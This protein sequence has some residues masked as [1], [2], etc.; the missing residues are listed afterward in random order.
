MDNSD[1]NYDTNPNVNIN[2]DPNADSD[3]KT[4]NMLL[5][6]SPIAQEQIK[7]KPH[8]TWHDPQS[9]AIRVKVWRSTVAKYMKFTPEKPTIKYNHAPTQEELDE[10]K[11]YANTQVSVIEED[12]LNA[13]EQLINEGYNP[14]VLNMADWYNAGGCVQGGAKTQEEELFRRSNYFTHLLQSFYPLDT[15]DLMIS[16]DVEVYRDDPYKD[17][18][19]RDKPFKCNIV[20]SPALDSPV[21][22]YKDNDDMIGKM[23]EEDT[24]IMYNK[25]RQLI[26]YAATAGCDSIVLSAW[27]CGAFHLPAW[28]ISQLFAKVLSESAGCL[29]KVVFAVTNHKNNYTIF[30][31]NILENHGSNIPNLNIKAPKV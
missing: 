11:V 30:K 9:P 5:F 14:L 29:R 1:N 21:L 19:I 18:A 10:L 12:T 3:I 31:Q 28:Q 22:D 23:N 15:Y 26:Y 16:Y 20:A 17:Y 2:T 24:E 8:Y 27:G 6:N 4:I 25:M 13:T 7:Q